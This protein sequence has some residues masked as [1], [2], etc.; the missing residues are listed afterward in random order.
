MNWKK[1]QD[2]TEHVPFP[3]CTTEAENSKER[4]VMV[5]EEEEEEGAEE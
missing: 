1:R 3:A 5:R 2:W 4:L